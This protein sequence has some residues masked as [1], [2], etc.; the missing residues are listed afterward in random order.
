MKE[1][2]LTGALFL[3]TKDKE[4]LKKK[5]DCKF[6]TI[7]T[8]KEGYNADYEVSRI[9]T[10]IGKFRERQLKQ[11]NKKIKEPEDKIKIIKT[12]INKSKCLKWMT[13]KILPD[14]EE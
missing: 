7:N 11:S 3:T 13:K 9:Q 6:I 1:H 4:T 14:Y 8:S 5:L 2:M 10:F 12:L